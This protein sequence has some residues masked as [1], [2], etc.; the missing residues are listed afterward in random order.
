MR[1]SYF[2][3]LIFIFATTL[4]AK[5]PDLSS[6]DP[7]AVLGLETNVSLDEV[8]RA[9]RRLA[10]K[11]HP[12]RNPGDKTAERNFK[13]VAEA[14]ERIQDGVPTMEWAATGT[15]ANNSSTYRFRG[16]SGEPVGVWF[17]R[18]NEAYERYFRESLASNFDPK[19]TAIS[20]AL[21][22]AMVHLGGWN[23]DPVQ[24][25][26]VLFATIGMD[27][28]LLKAIDLFLNA[29]M[30]HFLRSRPTVQAIRHL[31]EVAFGF[32]IG[33]SLNSPE[34]IRFKTAI[35]DLMRESL[36]LAH[37]PTDFIELVRFEFSNRHWPGSQNPNDYKTHYLL[38]WERAKQFGSRFG[39]RPAEFLA[40]MLANLPPEFD[41]HN[42]FIASTIFDMAVGEFINGLRIPE[43]SDSLSQ[44]DRVRI[45]IAARHL[46]IRQSNSTVYR[47]GNIPDRATAYLTRFFEENPEL[48]R[49]YRS[50][51]FGAKA[52][53][54]G[55][56]LKYFP[57]LAAPKSP[58]PRLLEGPK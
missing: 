35:S 5:E 47:L 51:V 53:L 37:T 46:G 43:I 39:T 10:L 26:H 36:V 24:N 7:Y 54:S 38:L 14:Y 49:R 11:Y 15:S 6:S 4:F 41:G 58:L 55:L 56:C 29:N 33:R 9:Y 52:F 8:K 28:P 31:G 25:I 23:T 32:G 22:E 44:E 13:D 45:L 12:D 3:I 57:T 19:E 27:A 20:Y 2:F 42:G 30:G 50:Q 40:G 16:F 17:N 1:T 34:W 48:S 21:K 18:L